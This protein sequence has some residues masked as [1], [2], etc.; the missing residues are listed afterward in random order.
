MGTPPFHFR[1]FRVDQTGSTHK[2]GTDGV[3]LG[4]WVGIKEADIHILDVGTGSGLIALMLAQRTGPASR[5][6]GVEIEK[7]DAKQAEEN[8][9]QSP[10]PEKIRIHPVAIQQFFPEKKYDLI[11]S[12]PPYFVNS[13]LPPEKKRSQARHTH[14]LSFE[15]LLMAASRLLTKQGR[16][17]LI[18]PYAEGL[19]FID[20]ARSFHLFP[21]RK[22]TFRSRVRNPAKR[23]LLELNHEERPADKSELILY[24]QGE[25]WSED[26]QK[27]TGEFYLKG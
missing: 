12:N 8:V 3:L 4:A 20:L 21:V 9:R 2:V 16:L 17:A 18:L 13:L 26:Y 24:N 22:T 11:I 15:D 6:E 25:N 10:W 1:Q 23:L 5:I 27:L 14:Q 19:K 7:D